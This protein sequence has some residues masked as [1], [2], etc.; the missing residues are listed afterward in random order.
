MNIEFENKDKPLM[1]N[2]FITTERVN[3]SGWYG[4]SR[5]EVETKLNWFWLNREE[6][7]ELKECLDTM[8]KE[9]ERLDKKGE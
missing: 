2:C 6:L 1:E 4:L 7:Y 3:I 5:F 8:I 9:I